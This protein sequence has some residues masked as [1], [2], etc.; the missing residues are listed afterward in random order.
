MQSHLGRY[1]LQRR[2]R[3]ARTAAGLY[4]FSR[5][6]ELDWERWRWFALQ[7]FNCR[8][9]PHAI[10]GLNLDGKFRGASVLVFNHV[11]QPEC[12]IDEKTILEL[13]AHLKGRIGDKFFIIAPRG[14]F[15]FQQDYIDLGGVR[16]YAL[17]IPYSVINELHRRVFSALQQPNDE[18]A[19]N[20]TVDAVGFDFIQPPEVKFAVGVKKPKGQL[21]NRTQ[22][23]QHAACN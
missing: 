2:E 12:R 18:M 3:W 10:G 16:Y 5:L 13:H 6:K 4:D 20:D 19:V 22:L 23:S 8:D 14:V 21:L 17:R 11:A 9:E 1:V 15:D 7:L